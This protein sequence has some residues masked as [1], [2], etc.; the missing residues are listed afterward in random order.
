[1]EEH[2]LPLALFLTLLLAARVGVK[3]H[4]LL[5]LTCLFC[6]TYSVI[7]SHWVVVWNE[8]DY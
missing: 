7:L 5:R 6:N 1:M 8:L 2:K 3:R 4:A